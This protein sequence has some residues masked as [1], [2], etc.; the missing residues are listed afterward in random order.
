[1]G[2]DG[3]FIG[4]DSVYFTQVPDLIWVRVPLWLWVLVAA[5][6]VTLSTSVTKAATATTMIFRVFIV[7]T[8]SGMDEA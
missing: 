3:F 7:F 8:S 5:K 1:V 6:A 2:K 4:H